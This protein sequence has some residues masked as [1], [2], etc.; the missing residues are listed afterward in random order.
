MDGEAFFQVAHNP[1]HPFRVA[2]G[3]AQVEVIGT[4]FDVVR[5]PSTIEVAVAEGA[6]L[7]D[8]APKR[9][10]L[11]AG[12]VLRS[13]D[14]HL[15]VAKTSER[16]VGSWRDARLTYSNAPIAR[17]AADISRTTGVRI[18]AS[19]EVASRTFSG[20]IIV[21]RDRDRLLRRVAALLDVDVRRSGDAWL[22]TSRR[23]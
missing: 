10:R 2:A 12:M 8:A 22:L 13:A 20:V 6:V 16:E 18:E 11:N 4:A 1:A 23:A 5:T 7:V 9:V 15:T 14:G 19:P 3:D 21:E 17:I